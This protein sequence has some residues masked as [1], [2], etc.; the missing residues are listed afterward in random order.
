MRRG[1]GRQAGR[2]CCR[3]NE[4]FSTSRVVQT[5]PLFR[6]NRFWHSAGEHVSAKSPADQGRQGAPLLQHRG[7]PPSAIGARGSAPSPV[8][9]RDQRQPTG[10]LA[11]DAGGVRR[12]AAR[13]HH[14]E[15]V[16]RRPAGSGGSRGQRTG[17]AQRDEAAARAALWQLLV[18]RRAVAAVGAGSIGGAEAG[19]GTGRSELGAGA[20]TTG[21]QSA[22]RSGQRVSSAPAM[23]RSKCHG[24][25]AGG[26]TSRWPKRIACT[27]AGTGS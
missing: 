13:L 4:T 2:K 11:Q 8:S 27:A 25:A 17:Q 20:G 18:G 14:A 16:S 10:S 6:G 21:G 19:A 26:W 3:V 1:F 9:G 5:C 23:V 22:D 15:P 12:A 24:R 7:K